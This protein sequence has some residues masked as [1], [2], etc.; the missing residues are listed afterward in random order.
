MTTTCTLRV[1]RPSQCA[2]L[3][4]ACCTR[5]G[6]C[7]CDRGIENGSG[8]LITRIN[9]FTKLKW[10]TTS[11]IAVLAVAS[12]EV[13]LFS[14]RSASLSAL[15]GSRSLANVGQQKYAYTR[16]TSK[17]VIHLVAESVVFANTSVGCSIV[18]DL[19]CSLLPIAIMWKIQL[20]PK[21]KISV[22]R[23]MGIGLV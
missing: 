17:L 3:R 6:C 23:V 16:S 10:L 7:S 19:I 15:R 4:T 12:L 1:K 11:V 20:P 18:T 22:C 14:W 21:K 5:L 8:L 2:R 9:N 13:V